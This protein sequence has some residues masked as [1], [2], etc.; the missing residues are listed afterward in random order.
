MLLVQVW[1]INLKHPTMEIGLNMNHI[2]LLL[3]YLQYWFIFVY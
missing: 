1:K 3:V 2:V